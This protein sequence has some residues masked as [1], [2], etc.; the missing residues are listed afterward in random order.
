MF[1]VAYLAVLQPSESCDFLERAPRWCENVNGTVGAKRHDSTGPTIHAIKECT[2]RS[3]AR[4]KRHRPLQSFIIFAIHCPRN[5]WRRFLF[6]IHDT[7][8]FLTHQ[9]VSTSTFRVQSYHISCTST[10]LRC[11]NSSPHHLTHF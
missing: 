8:R 6:V 4:K 1:P 10:I 3:I 5:Y 9:T 11:S 7:P 2:L